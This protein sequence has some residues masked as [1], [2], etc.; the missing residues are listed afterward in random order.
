MDEKGQRPAV[1]GV[2]GWHNSGKTVLVEALVAALRA[3]GLRVC[4]I[5]HA[6][7]GFQIDEPGSDSARM[8]EAGAE[9]VAVVGPD[10]L[11][12]RQRVPKPTL[13]D[14]LARL[15]GNCD[16]ILVEGFKRARL[17]RVVIQVA[18]SE[19]LPEA[20]AIRVL[21]VEEQGLLPESPAVEE[22]V[23]AVMTWLRER[24]FV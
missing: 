2:S 15:K 11:L 24:C 3:K 7:R 19:P 1:L 12:I 20:Q 21:K 9:A 16:V 18:G 17:P 14:A 5:K 6:A 13:D 22:A 23:G 4:T 8:W 10:E